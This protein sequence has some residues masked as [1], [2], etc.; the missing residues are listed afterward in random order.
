MLSA[1]ATAALPTLDDWM[2]SPA[3]PLAMDIRRAAAA[4]RASVR[5]VYFDRGQGRTAN[6]SP[7]DRT[8]VR[9]YIDDC[10]T[11]YRTRAI[12]SGRTPRSRASYI[13]R[14]WR[15]AQRSAWLRNQRAAL[16]AR[17]EVGQ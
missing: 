4:H 10:Y 11:R 9:S 1:T 3:P 12:I 5:A 2:L 14:S 8:L 7:A 16:R 15:F 6:L 13:A 17:I